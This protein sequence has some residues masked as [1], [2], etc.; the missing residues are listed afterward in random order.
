MLSYP[1][2]VPVLSFLHVYMFVH[3]NTQRS[4]NLLVRKFVKNAIE[5]GSTFTYKGE[6]WKM[7]LPSSN[8]QILCCGHSK[9]PSK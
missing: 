2:D 1:L 4:S 5:T 3:Y 6:Y 8:Y 9:E 7:N